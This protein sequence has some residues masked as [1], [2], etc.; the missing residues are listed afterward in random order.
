MINFLIEALVVREVKEEKIIIIFNMDQ[1]ILGEISHKYL[2]STTIKLE[3]EEMSL[4]I[5][6]CCNRVGHFSV[7]CRMPNNKLSKFKQPSTSTQYAKA[8][9]HDDNQSGF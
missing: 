4:F 3:E 7:D 2:Q 5:C 6:K 9:D 1:I 8:N